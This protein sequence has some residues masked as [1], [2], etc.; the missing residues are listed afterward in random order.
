MT[1]I[2]IIMGPI[3]TIGGRGIGWMME[4]EEIGDTGGQDEENTSKGGGCNTS[5][6]TYSTEKCPPDPVSASLNAYF[7]PFKMRAR[8]ILMLEQ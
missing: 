7:M 2:F 4:Q 8:Y 6:I 1:M 5:I 3:P